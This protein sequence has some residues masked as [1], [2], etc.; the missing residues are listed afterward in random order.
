[1][2]LGNTVVAEASNRERGS[3]MK[4]FSNE[5]MICCGTLIMPEVKH[6]YIGVW[7]EWRCSICHSRR[8]QELGEIDTRK[9][10]TPKS[11]IE[12]D[13]RWVDALPRIKQG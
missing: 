9:S 11:G 6:F 7:V 2:Y 10:R 1:M 4:V 12:H 5:K 8:L 3:E 13:A